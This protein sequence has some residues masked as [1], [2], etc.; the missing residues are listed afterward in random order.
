MGGPVRISTMG[1]PEDQWTPRMREYEDGLERFCDQARADISEFAILFNAA[2]KDNVPEQYEKIMMD[3]TRLNEFKVVRSGDPASFN[4][5]SKKMVEGGHLGEVPSTN[6][7]DELM[8][9]KPG[10]PRIYWLRRKFSLDT[11]GASLLRKLV[12]HSYR[13]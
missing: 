4:R 3:Y 11:A 5:M 6:W 1:Y 8:D 12:E 7:M 9:I 10:N 13:V 2:V